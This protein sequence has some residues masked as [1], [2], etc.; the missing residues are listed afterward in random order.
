[1]SAHALPEIVAH[2]GN[3]GEYPE[4][5]LQ[6]LSSAVDLGV[7][8]LEFDVQLTADK[9]PVVFHDSTLQ[10][11]AGRTD[12]I[13]DLTWTQLAEMPVGEV[14]RFGARF[15]YTYPTSLAQTVD[16]IAGWDGVT[17]FVEIK[18]ASMRRFG[19]E[20]VLTRVAEIVRPVLDRCVFISFDLPSLK[21]LRM[22][23]GARVGWVLTDYSDAAL[24]DAQSLAPE[25]LFCDLEQV[26]A[27]AAKLW[28]GP[29]QWAV[30]E[31][32]NLEAAQRCQALGASF[33]ETMLVTELLAIYD[34][35]RRSG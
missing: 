4:N 19:R 28:D 5:T 22:M 25:F 33:V 9:V 8:Y 35:H 30:Y 3:A 6:A 24:Q 15:A 1:M 2:R 21:I 14:G 17:A 12:C 31:V 10:R 13:H 34:E 26:P 27:L 18:R 32:R 29:W 23:T 16:A 20:V 7:R 11:V